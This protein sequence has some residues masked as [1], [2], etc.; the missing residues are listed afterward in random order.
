MPLAAGGDAY[1]PA[2][3]QALCRACHIVKTAAENR[4]QPTP[5]SEAWQRL[6]EELL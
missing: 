3:V 1:D 5:E 4:R 6:V 2:N